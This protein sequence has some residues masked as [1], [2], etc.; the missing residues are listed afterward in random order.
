M[1]EAPLAPGGRSFQPMPLD[2]RGLAGPFDII[3]DVH[4]CG[5]ELEALLSRLGYGVALTGA[6]AARHAVVTAP[7]GRTAVFV[8]DLVDRGPRTPDVLRI[9]MAMVAAGIGLC[10]P[11]NHDA[12]LTRWLKGNKVEPTHGLDISIRQFEAE[13]AALRGEVERFFESLP[14]HLW[15]DGGRLAVSHAGILE[16]MLGQVSDRVR[17]FCLYGDTDGQRDE[18]GLSIRY[19]WAVGHTGPTTIVYGHIPVAEPAWVNN[20]VCIDTACCFGN[21]LTAMRWPEREMVSVAAA[22]TY[23][24]SKRAFGLPAPRG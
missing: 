13:P 10:V 3:G 12:K 2:Q 9:V 4:G 19:N 22:G 8:G 11:G 6:G 14:F 16:P 18:K 15:L 5:D 7:R 21:A 24:A 1:T 20:A 17:R 23:Y